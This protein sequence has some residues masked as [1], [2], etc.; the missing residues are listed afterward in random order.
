MTN[1]VYIFTQLQENFGT[2]CKLQSVISNIL[3][4]SVLFLVG[5]ISFVRAKII[6]K[7]FQTDLQFFDDF[8]NLSYSLSNA[9]IF[10]NSELITCNVS[11]LS[12]SFCCMCSWVFV[13]I[14]F[15]AQ[16]PLSS[17]ASFTIDIKGESMLINSSSKRWRK[18]I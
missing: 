18:V 17:Y 13:K 14:V 12:S 6:V 10:C 8:C 9:C 15:F 7:K 5:L 11:L 2:S 4:L 3:Y 1:R 16:R